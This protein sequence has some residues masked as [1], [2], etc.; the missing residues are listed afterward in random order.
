MLQNSDII[1]Q[2]DLHELHNF[3]VEHLMLINQKKT[4][5]M[6][7]NPLRNY[8]FMPRVTLS[9]DTDQYIDVVE[10]HKLLGQIIRTDMRTISNTL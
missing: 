2:T 6:L 8:D 7:F 5:V 3:T 4:K 1:L 10:E 9:N